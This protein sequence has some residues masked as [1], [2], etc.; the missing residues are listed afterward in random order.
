MTFVAVF[1]E[2]VSVMKA[3]PPRRKWTATRT[4]HRLDALSR[5]MGASVGVD[6]VRGV[7]RFK[8]GI[9][10]HRVYEAWLQADY[11][12]ITE[13]IPWDQL[14]SELDPPFNRVR[15][16]MGQS[17]DLS[18]QALPVPATAE[19]RFDTENPRIR[20]YIAGRRAHNFTNLSEDSAANIQHWT[21]QSFQRA[22]TP[23]QVADQ[24]KDSIGLL[25]RHAVAVERYREGLTAGGMPGVRADAM[26]AD[27]ADRLLDYRAMMIGRTET[28]LATN[29]GQLAVW[30]QAADQEMFDRSTA[31]KVW[32][33]DGNPCEICEPMDG[34]AVPLDSSWLLVADGN[35]PVD[36]P[37]ESHPHCYCGMELEF[38]EEPAR[39][40]GEDDDG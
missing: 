11:G 19:L 23:R 8:R 4:Y 33:V 20:E 37:T 15:G 22:L 27:Y 6:L 25:P 38:N 12:K 3:R 29:R 1:K 17:W 39:A 7:Q 28:R 35:R 9:D 16:V 36:I 31:R 40:G 26:A 21:T 24:V 10:P 34:R 18:R 5:R 14:A 32:V 2:N 30:Q 13:S